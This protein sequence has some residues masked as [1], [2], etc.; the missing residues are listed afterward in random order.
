MIPSH[1]ALK[2]PG[3]AIGALRFFRPHMV[4]VRGGHAATF[5]RLLRIGPF[6]FYVIRYRPGWVEE[7]K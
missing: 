3:K 2:K 4:N 5:R 7:G 1:W 6:G